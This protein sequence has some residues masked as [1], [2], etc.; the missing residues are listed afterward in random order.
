[1]K[2]WTIHTSDFKLSE[3]LVDHSKSDYYNNTPGVKEAYH[4]LWPLIEVQDGQIVWCY[5]RRQDVPKT[6]TPK[7]LWSLEMPKSSV[8]RYIDDIMWNCILGIKVCLTP[9]YKRNIKAKAATMSPNDP[10]RRRIFERQLEKEF[11]EN[12]PPVKELWNNLLLDKAVDGS[13]ALIKHP[14]PDD[15]IIGSTTIQCK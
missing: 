4:R 10:R 13:P 7:I 9:T 6:G 14:V 2:L 8:I 12:K 5:T 3:G 11:W 15:W 1:M